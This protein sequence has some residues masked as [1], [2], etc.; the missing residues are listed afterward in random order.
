MNLDIGM[1][2]QL[3]GLIV[4]DYYETSEFFKMIFLL[5]RE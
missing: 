3:E 1:G 4:A 5:L 2:P